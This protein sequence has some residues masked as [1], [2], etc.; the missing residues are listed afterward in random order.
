[1]ARWKRTDPMR[2]DRAPILI[3]NDGTSDVP[4]LKEFVAGVNRSSWAAK[5]GSKFRSRKE[6]LP[7]GIAG[8]LVAA[9]DRIL[10][11]SGDGAIAKVYF[12]TMP[13]PPPSPD[14]NRRAKYEELL[15]R[16]GGSAPKSPCPPST[17]PRKPS[18]GQGCQPK[19]SG[20]PGC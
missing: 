13:F 9:W 19:K 20:R 16:A 4:R 17:G 8:E 10:S 12:E 2:F 11:A 14:L 5:F 6:A 7:P 15:R 3:R 1:M 18:G